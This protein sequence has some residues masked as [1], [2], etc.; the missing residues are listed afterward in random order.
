MDRVPAHYWKATRHPWPC[1]VFL[2]PLLV[3]YEVGV[4]WLGGAHPE[5]IRNGVDTWLHWSL[6]AAGLSELY[7]PPVL[8]VLVFLAWSWSR[9]PDRP[10]DLLGIGTGMGMESLVFAGGLFGL[11]RALGPILDSL[12][13][14]LALPGQ[15]D[16]VVTQMVTFVGAGIYEEVLFRL[17][18]FTGIAWLL[19]QAGIPALLAILV[20]AFGSS[21]IFSA[22]HHAGPQGETFD[23]YAFLFR[24]LAGLYFTGVFQLRGFGIAVGAHA[25]YDVMVGVIISPSV[26]IPG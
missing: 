24:T 14:P 3:V 12:G 4:L 20:G 17:G 15:T 16:Q 26:S 19:R 21:L 25:C 11:S 23:G 8:I 2:I 9:W 6:E 1:L 5:A 18:L 7:W 13:I 10:R 22:A